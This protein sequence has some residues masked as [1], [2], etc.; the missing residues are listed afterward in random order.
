M[1]TW[2]KPCLTVA[3]WEFFRYFK[4]KDQ[5][6]GVVAMIFGAAIGY[7]AM[8]LS[9]STSQ[10]EL[11]V[12]GA[13]DSFAFADKGNLKLAEGTNDEAMWQQMVEAGKVDGLLKI[14]ASSREG[15]VAELIVRK[16]PAWLEEL[17]PIVE[18]E[19]LRWEIL[20]AQIPIGTVERLLSPS[21]I[22]IVS[23]S[24]GETSKGDRMI[25]YGMLVAMLLTSWIG[26]AYM[27]TGITGEKQM[28]VTEQVVSAIRPQAWIDGK[29]LGISGAAIGSLAFLFLTGLICLPAANF[30]GIDVALP[31]ALKRW[32]L[33]PLLLVYYLGGVFFWN[34]FYAAVAAVINDPN[35]SS[36]TSLLFL[37]MLP[38]MAAGFVA[39]KPDG[40]MMKTL[41]IL[42]GASSTAMPMR[43]ILG[44]VSYLETIS[45]ILFL[46][47][48]IFVLRTIAGRVFAA[49]IMLYGKEPTWVDILKWSLTKRFDGNG[50]P[51]VST[52]LMFCCLSVTVGPN[53]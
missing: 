21:K 45:S 6:I 47:L 50:L 35:T 13:S 10:V 12:L 49:G 26:L 1:M 42:P 23:L 2:L 38:M 46:L 16:E 27:M 39:S 40:A 32:D 9:Q 18:A 14:N 4:W 34:C 8:R 19:K 33:V 29:L 41:S 48:G 37:P 30:L 44:E 31:G 22:D 53:G 52:L 25:A 15:F 17:R 36:R 7:A 20:D 43:M 51:I 3:R 28:R 5:L 24:A 11:A